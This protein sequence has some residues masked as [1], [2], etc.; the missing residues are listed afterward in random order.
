M[1]D[2][3]QTLS[4]FSD[5]QRTRA[6]ELFEKLQNIAEVSVDFNDIQKSIDSIHPVKVIA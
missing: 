6:I 5:D 1:E 4:A 3:Q 2:F